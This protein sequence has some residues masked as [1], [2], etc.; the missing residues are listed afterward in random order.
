[1]SEKVPMF[2]FL[3]Q[4]FVISPCWQ[5]LFSTQKVKPHLQELESFLDT[6]YKEKTI[7]PEKKDIFKAFELCSKKEIKV[8]ILGQDPY[9]GKGQA[10]GLS[11]SVP[12][13]IKTPPSLRNIHKAIF[14]NEYSKQLISNDLTTWAKQG[15]LLLNTILT[16][17]EKKP[18]SHK[19]KGWEDFTDSIIKDVSSIG[20]I[21]FILWGAQA[22][23]KSALI[24]NKKN[25]VLSGVHPSPLSAYRGFFDSD[26][27]GEA[28]KYL[29]LNNKDLIKWKSIAV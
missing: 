11:F 20:G 1:M 3:N 24:D 17:E 29:L 15:V 14:K 7:F 23:K 25:L 2:R 12:K 6:R 10:H 8:V 5:E 27:F 13:D 18:N 4:N 28:N 26:H 19:S 9:H 16:V 22:I 21:V